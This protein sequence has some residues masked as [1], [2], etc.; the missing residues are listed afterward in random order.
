MTFTR[1]G[2]RGGAL[3]AAMTLFL[4]CSLASC[5]LCTIARRSTRYV[6]YELAY[7]SAV[8]SAMMIR[9]SATDEDGGSTLRFLFAQMSDLEEGALNLTFYTDEDSRL[10][11]SICTVSFDDDHTVHAVVEC[12]MFAFR[13]DLPATETEGGVVWRREDSKIVRCEK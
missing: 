4:L 10:P 13:V 11:P 1:R 9:D 5:M 12:K 8:S 3:G 6:E 7:R 2:P